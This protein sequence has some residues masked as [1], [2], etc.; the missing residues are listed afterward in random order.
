M[1]FHRDIIDQIIIIVHPD[2]VGVHHQT[3]SLLQAEVVVTRVE[4]VDP[5]LQVTPQEEVAVDLVQDRLDLQVL[6]HHE[7]ED[8]RLD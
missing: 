1:V 2:T 5:D 4:A 3:H 7:A 6:H 8:S